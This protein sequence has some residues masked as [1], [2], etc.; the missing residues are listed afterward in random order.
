MNFIDRNVS[1]EQAIIILAKNGVQVNEKEAKIILELL[2][3]VSKN[4]DKPKEKKILE[5]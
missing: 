4:Y 1:V 5:P 3:L 2:Y